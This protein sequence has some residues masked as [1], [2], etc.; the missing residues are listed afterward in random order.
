MSS[1][2]RGW[3]TSVGSLFKMSPVL[4]NAELVFWEHHRSP[5]F[6]QR[7]EH[8][9]LPGQTFPK[10]TFAIDFFPRFNPRMY[11]RDSPSSTVWGWPLLILPGFHVGQWGPWMCLLTGCLLVERPGL[12]Q[13]TPSHCSDEEECTEHNSGSNFLHVSTHPSRPFPISGSFPPP[14]L[15]HTLLP[16]R[17]RFR[18]VVT[19][20]LI[21][22]LQHPQPWH[23]GWEGLHL[24]LPSFPVFKTFL[25][26]DT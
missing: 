25:E 21:F 12:S 8:Q 15:L 24:S 19:S 7:R 18:I 22:H 16:L 20:A 4:P 10:A 17:L 23:P 13:K 26:G 2:P 14:G 6:W 9:C 1:G 5:L 3:V 11:K